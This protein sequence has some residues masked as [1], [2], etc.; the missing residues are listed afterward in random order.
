[1]ASMQTKSNL[2]STPKKP[3]PTKAAMQQVY[4][5][6]LWGTNQSDF[7]SGEGSHDPKIVKPYLEAVGKFLGSFD[8]PLTVCDLGC[9]DFNVGRQLLS[10]SQ[11]YIAVDIVPELIDFNTANFSNEKIEFHCLD[12][13]TQ[14]LPEADCAL[15]RQVFQHLS[16]EE[17]KST[18]SKLSQYKYLILTE[19]IPNGSFAPNKDIISGQGIRIKKRSGVDVLT[20]PF[21]L[22]IKTQKELASIVLENGKG[23]IK[24]V[25]YTL[26]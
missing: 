10:L 15:L 19:H 21:H 8:E 22:K 6:K 24:T 16:N 7:Y 14:H 3:W 12:I 25:L 11:K 20:A 1:M 5:K 4:E 18:L 2:S 17:I 26:F 9:G 23:V 13:A